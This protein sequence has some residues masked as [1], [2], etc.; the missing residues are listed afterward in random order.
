MTDGRMQAYC[1]DYDVISIYVSKRFYS[2]ESKDFYLRDLRGLRIPLKIEG[3][4]NRSTVQ[5]YT[6]RLKEGS[7]EIGRV[8]DVVE[9]HGL[10]VDLEYRYVV[11]TAKFNEMFFNNREDFGAT[12]VGG[13]TLFV[14]WAP[15]ASSVSVVLNPHGEKRT[16]TMK[17]VEKGAW[18]LRVA[19]NLHGQDYLY[20]INI[21]GKTVESLDPYAYG[22]TANSKSSSII[23]YKQID[24]D[25]YDTNLEPFK[26]QTDAIIFEANV[27]DFSS[28][29][30]TTI[31]HKSQFWGMTE[32][33]A[34]TFDDQ[35]AGFDYFTSLGATHIQLMPVNDFT[36]VD[37]LYPKDYY[38]WGYDPMQYNA[39]EGS[40]STAPNDPL[41]RV[42]EFSKLVSK[43]HKQGIRV[44]LDVVY[45]HMA[46]I[47]RSPFDISVPYSFFRRSNTGQ[48]SNGSYCGNDVDSE[49]PMVRKYI[50]DSVLHFVRHY[51]IDG[52]RFDLM[53]IL[54]VDTMIELERRVRAEKPSI[55]LY[56][57]GW[58]LP[59]FLSDDKKCSIKNASKTPRIGYFNDY[60]RDNVKGP[61]NTS[62]KHIR[63]YALGDGRYR[64][65]FKASLVANTQEVLGSKMFDS[66]EQ[67]ICYV[68]AHDNMTLW[69]KIQECCRGES[70][71]LMAKRQ[72]FVNGVIALSQGVCFY[73]M[74]QEL[75]RTKYGVD[76][77]YM[78]SDEINKV[79]YSRAG[80]FAEV[81][82]YTQDMINL[83]KW[84][85]IFRFASSEEISEHVYFEDLDSDILLMRM[86]NVSRYTQFDEVLV[87]FNPFTQSKKID[88]GTMHE[89][90]ADENG[91]REGSVSSFTINPISIVVL[92]KPLANQPDKKNIQD[93]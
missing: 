91:F 28:D 59:T 84:L 51:H 66:P 30:N 92:A 58:D 34:V 27:R 83:R 82:R 8:Y 32:K 25:F 55:M 45:N 13:V 42:I 14:I 64:N 47:G 18:Q 31:V 36:S 70:K 20:L 60:Y 89:I 74:G 22:S 75:C 39:L 38:N 72:M 93:S 62:E 69:D 88:L 61:T 86:R 81:L 26:S 21:N 5:K 43:F 73:H 56:G 85:P 10:S 76:N 44:N 1:D 71:A 57:E 29:P 46:D 40:Y 17:R 19:E 79:D 68:E 48:V 90:L 23:D 87:Y 33:R 6:C 52:F 3:V 67:S 15:T 12:V 50:I 63:G 54:D 37:E 9:N 4:E 65:A 7:I 24:V 78:S 11:R 80:E 53:G 49:K 41:S 35:P 16:F 77:S 2:G